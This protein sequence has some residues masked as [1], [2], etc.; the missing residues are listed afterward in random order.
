MAGDKK[1]VDHINSNRL[2]CRRSN[3]RFVTRSQNMQKATNRP[4]S[5]TGYKG[6]ELHPA[7]PGRYKT[8]RYY[9]IITVA[10]NKISLGGYSN[11][12]DAA[13]AYNK[14]ALHHYGPHAGINPGV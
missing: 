11:A 12:A 8:D 14:A 1:E 4:T 13:R 3:L 2:D 7:Q 9:A 10:G 6:V 5:Q